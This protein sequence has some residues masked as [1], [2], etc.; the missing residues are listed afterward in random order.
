M[1]DTTG[2]LGLI[3]KFAAVIAVHHVH[4]HQEGLAPDTVFAE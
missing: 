1:F 2:D 4:F 3:C